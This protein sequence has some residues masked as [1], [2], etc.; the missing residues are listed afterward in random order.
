[1][2]VD[3]I[4]HNSRPNKQKGKQ[5]IPNTLIEQ[6]KNSG[7]CFKCGS[8]D[9]WGSEHPQDKP[10]IY[11]ATGINRQKSQIN[12]NKT[13]T[14]QPKKC[15]NPQQMRQHI[16]ALIEENFAKGTEE[17]EEFV[18]EVEEQGF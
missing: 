3:H 13:K 16:R 4:S 8:Q 1:M 7:A 11:T 12:P 10:W 6:R 14:P 2:D 5:R 18:K 17:Y 15:F 9:H